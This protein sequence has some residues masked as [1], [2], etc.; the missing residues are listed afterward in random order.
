MLSGCDEMHGNGVCF[1]FTQPSLHTCGCRAHQPDEA[2]KKHKER[3]FTYSGTIIVWR[4]EVKGDR[5][6]EVGGLAVTVRTTLKYRQYLSIP[7][8]GITRV[9][10]YHPDGTT[11][12]LVTSDK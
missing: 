1:I 5:G 7:G 4:A 11:T 8:I 10:H 12:N 2:P 3:L 6:Q 9:A